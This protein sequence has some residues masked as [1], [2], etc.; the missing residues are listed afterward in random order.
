MPSWESRIVIE[1]LG[2]AYRGPVFL[3]G[4][5]DPM[6]PPGVH[7]LSLPRGAPRPTMWWGRVPFSGR[8]GDVVHVQ[9][10]YTVVEGTPDPGYR[11]I[12]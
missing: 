11:Q 1:D 7:H 2:C 3:Y 10:L 9:R 6:M 4:G 8:P 12:V 5:P